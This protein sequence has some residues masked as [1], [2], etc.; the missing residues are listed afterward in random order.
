MKQQSQAA[1]QFSG[2]PLAVADPKQKREPSLA[3]KVFRKEVNSHTTSIQKSKI[4]NDPL[5]WDEKW[6]NGYE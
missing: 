5:Y 1:L 4:S 2:Y 3:L 6:F